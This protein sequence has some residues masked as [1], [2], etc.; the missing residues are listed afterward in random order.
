LQTVYAQVV[1]EIG[2]FLANHGSFPRLR[3]PLASPAAYRTVYPS[4]E[5]TPQRLFPNTHV[6]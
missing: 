6:R 5:E 4:K 1:H 2:E 3:M